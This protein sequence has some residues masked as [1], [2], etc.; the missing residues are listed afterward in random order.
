MC[1]VPLECFLLHILCMQNYATFLGPKV[2]WVMSH[3]LHKKD[4]VNSSHTDTSIRL[5]TS[6]H[7]QHL[8]VHKQLT[9]SPTN[10]NDNQLCKLHCMMLHAATQCNRDL[11]R[12][13]A[14]KSTAVQTDDVVPAIAAPLTSSPVRP[15][16]Q[17]LPPCTESPILHSSP[18]EEGGSEDEVDEGDRT[19]Y[20]SMNESTLE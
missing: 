9:F 7:G 13:I 12:L 3:L 1:T 10:N 8:W 6:Q 4:D 18:P 14:L 20:P 16:Q 11:Q 19:Y 15:L 5:Q 17:E 2:S